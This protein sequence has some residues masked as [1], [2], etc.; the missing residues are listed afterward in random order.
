MR[1]ESIKLIEENIGGTHFD[2]N[3]SNTFLALS[4]KAKETEAKINK[5]D[6][7]KLQRFFTAKETTCKNI[8][9]KGL[10]SKVYKQL[11]QLNIKKHKQPNWKVGR[12]CKR[13][14]FQGRHTDG[15]QANEKVSHVVN[16]Q[17]NTN[18]NHNEILPYTYQNVYQ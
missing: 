11:I 10:I 16:C 1:P 5:W 3:H 12:R 9:D 17:R 13:V 18:H 2:T 15:Q 7:I 6:L 14:I 8:T 4:S